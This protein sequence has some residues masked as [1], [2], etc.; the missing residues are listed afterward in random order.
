MNLDWSALLVCREQSTICRPHRQCH[1]PQHSTLEARTKQAFALV[2]LALRE[3]GSD[4]GLPSTLSCVWGI[5]W[6]DQYALYRDRVPSSPPQALA[7]RPSTHPS[8]PHLG[9]RRPPLYLYCAAMYDK[10]LL[11]VGLIHLEQRCKYSISRDIYALC[12]A[13]RYVLVAERKQSIFQRQ[14]L[15][16]SKIR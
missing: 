12:Y 10:G 2:T 5:S 14:H 3:K 8:P 7:G 6:G 16:S 11:A 15:V 13:T 9:C 4:T 1:A